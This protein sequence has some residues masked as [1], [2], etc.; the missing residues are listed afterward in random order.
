[1]FEAPIQQ[2]RSKYSLDVPIPPGN[3]ELGRQRVEKILG[4][5]PKPDPAFAIPL[6]DGA[7]GDFDEQLKNL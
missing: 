7:N 6:D 2:L 1:M 5:L 4:A 3:V